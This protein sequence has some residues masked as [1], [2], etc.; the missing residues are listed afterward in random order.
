MSIIVAILMAS[1]MDDIPGLQIVLNDL[2]AAKRLGLDEAQ[3]VAVMHESAAEV[4]ALSDA[5]G[6]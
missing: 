4:S 6:D 2:G 1:Q 3:T 5:L